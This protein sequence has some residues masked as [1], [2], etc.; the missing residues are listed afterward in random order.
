MANNQGT[1][2]R[3]LI[4]QTRLF[5][6]LERSFT[7]DIRREKNRYIV[8]QAFNFR[9]GRHLSDDLLTEHIANMRAVLKK[10]HGRV[11]RVFAGDTTRNFETVKSYRNYEKK[12]DLFS[13]LLLEWTN[14][15]GANKVQAIA[16]TTH[17]DL[18]KILRQS[19][20]EEEQARDTVKRL[21]SV[22]SLSQSRAAAIART[23]THNAAMF[24]S[25]RTAEVLATDAQV[26]IL[27][28]WV[29]ALDERTRFSHVEMRNH[30][31]VNM[32]GKFKVSR[33]KGGF[34]MMDRPGDPTASAGN[35]I[36][37]RC[38]L[39]FEPKE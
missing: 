14:E 15:E 23:E 35:V 33:P 12:R 11:L 4:R 9:R 3:A 30:P 24:A 27:K 34:D 28:R 38:V 17:N 5:S 20:E 21:L 7:R 26:Q 22:R 16:A 18:R 37:C 6:R 29:P 19:I 13:L 39:V 2:I 10:H 25:K 31:P 8:A 36:H 32:D 1:N